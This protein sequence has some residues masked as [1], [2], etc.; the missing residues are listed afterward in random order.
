MTRA[1]VR[2]ALA[3]ALLAAAPAAADSGPR[4][5]PLASGVAES[6]RG[7]SVVD[8]HVAWVSGTRGHVGRTTDGGS[9]WT[10]TRV[11][12]HE[13]RDFRDV[14]AFSAERA[15][16]VAVAS[17]GL[18]LETL[19][20]GST[21]IE[22]FRDERAEVFLDGLD[23][24]GERCVAFG[25]PI[26]SRF[27][28]VASDDAGRSWRPVEGPP[29]LEG[30]AAFAASGRSVRIG[31]DRRIRIGT[32]GT[33]ARV[34]HE[35]TDGWQ[36]AATPLAAGAA[37]RGVFALAE[38]GGG[39]W[40]AVGGDFRAESE[41]AGTAARSDDG[42]STWRAAESAPGGYRSAVESLG[43]DRLLATG[44]SGTDSSEDGGRTWRPLAADGFHVVARARSG[45]L[46][47]FAG[48]DGRLARLR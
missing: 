47:L 23:C 11:A 18:I 9:T 39:R 34:L 1:I 5:E 13:E 10:F 15:L 4:L 33:S 38:V 35:T 29:A 48:A 16:V 3:S 7:L 26:G 6:L 42:G 36:A 8:D 45:S 22:R 19:D 30:E 46:V 21:W 24:S 12:G 40:V 43:G 14:E 20:G 44:P 17:P 25:D 31:A 28:L 27:L 37:S 2:S 32:G 41:R